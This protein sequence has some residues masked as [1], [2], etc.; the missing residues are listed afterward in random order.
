MG[1][2]KPNSSM[3][4]A[5]CSTCLAECVRGLFPYSFKLE[6]GRAEMVGEDERAECVMWSHLEN[7]TMP[8]QDQGH[9]TCRTNDECSGF[10]CEGQFKV[11]ILM[12][13]SPSPLS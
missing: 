13:R 6:T 10:T 2:L 4:R 11:S 5:S 7:K 8:L 12:E 1:L 9:A 3:D